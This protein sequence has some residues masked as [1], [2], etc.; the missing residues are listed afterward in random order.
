MELFKK[1]LEDEDIWSGLQIPED[2]A[3]HFGLRHGRTHKDFVAND[4]EG[5]E[6]SFTLEL[7][8]HC[9]K[10]HLSG[11][12]LLFVQEK[13]LKT[14]HKLT[15]SMEEQWDYRKRTVY[16][17]KF[18]TT[19]PNEVYSETLVNMRIFADNIETHFT[20]LRI[21]LRPISADP[22]ILTPGYTGKELFRKNL[23]KIDVR[24]G[25]RIPKNLVRDLGIPE[26]TD[27]VEFEAIDSAGKGRR[28]TILLPNDNPNWV[29]TWLP[30]VQEKGIRKGHSVAFYQKLNVEEGGREYE[31]RVWAHV[32]GGQNTLDK[33]LLE[34]LEMWKAEDCCFPRPAEAN[35]MLVN[36]V[37]HAPGSLSVK[38]RADAAPVKHRNVENNANIDIQH[39]DGR[40]TETIKLIINRDRDLEASGGKDHEAPCKWAASLSQKVTM[41][42]LFVIANFTLEVISTI[43]DQLSSADKPHYAIVGITASVTAMLVCILE[44]IH[45]ALK[46]GGFKG[47]SIFP[48]IVGW[49][50]AVCQCTVTFI[51]C[52]F[53][54]HGHIDPPIKI[55]VWPITYAFFLLWAMLNTTTDMRT[56]TQKES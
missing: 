28:F 39:S 36:R 49:V 44:L 45:G 51:N 12:W 48:D 24:D 13:G 23:S 54:I 2:H 18:Q 5:N 6:W 37:R 34:K 42:R 55:S 43:F 32:S 19:K 30:F 11:D 4:R 40:S 15:F 38:D 20:P 16:K 56:L 25:L 26:G 3:E 10:P 31:I 1:I 22:N 53:I 17:L 50:C 47:F 14:G 52:G 33:G 27:K 7:L 21:P 8:R 9:H 46:P 29:M 41:Q 35:P